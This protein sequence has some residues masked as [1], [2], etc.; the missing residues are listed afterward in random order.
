MLRVISGKYKGKKL[1]C[2]EEAEI[3]PTKEIAKEGLF[4]ILDSD[5]FLKNGERLLVGANVLDV[6]AGTGALAI[7][8]ISRGARSA[9]LI[10]NN[11][12][13]IDVARKNISSIQEAENIK[14]LKAD[15][16]SLPN[17]RERY[18][19][20]FIDPPYQGNLLIKALE[21]LA[22]KAWFNPLAIVVCESS[23][24][25]KIEFS[26]HFEFLEERQYGKSKFT[27]LR[28]KG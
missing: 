25:E 28:F 8:A 20:V 24:K 11:P 14:I 27:F 26:E 2:E 15:A 1:F 6:F 16:T 10:D 23:S 7:E 21:Q 9:T 12:Q 5:K 22:T 18:D 13:H 19:V 4:S 3:R 17:S